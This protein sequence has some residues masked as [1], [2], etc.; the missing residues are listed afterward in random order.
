MYSPDIAR[1]S[2]SIVVQNERGETRERLTLE[3]TEARGGGVVSE[4]KAV[5]EWLKKGC[6]ETVTRD[7][8]SKGMINKI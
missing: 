8:L 6:K 2:S 5:G 1:L 3:V 7:V 4:G